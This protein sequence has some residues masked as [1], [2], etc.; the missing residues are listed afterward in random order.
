LIERVILSAGAMLIFSVSFQIDQMPEGENKFSYLTLYHW[1]GRHSSTQS[2]EAATNAPYF[3]Q[4]GIFIHHLKSYSSNISCRVRYISL[5]DVSR[6]SPKFM[7]RSMV[8]SLRPTHAW[9]WPTGPGRYLWGFVY[10]YCIIANRS[11]YKV[12]KSQLFLLS[13]LGTQYTSITCSTRRINL[14]FTQASL[15]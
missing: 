13:Q 7:G 5:I 3:F 15:S 6:F 11:I 1:V 2:S 9:P 8:Y 12:S 10:F 4:R 14:H